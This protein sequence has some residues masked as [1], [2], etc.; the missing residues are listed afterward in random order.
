MK[1]QNERPGRRL[2]RRATYVL[3]LAAFLAALSFLLGLL[4]KTIQG[5]SPLR[6]T[7]EG[8]PVVLSGIMLGPFVGAAVG[9]AADLLSCLLAGQSPLPLITVGAAL[10]GL[11]PG[12]LTP[13]LYRGARPFS[14]RPRFLTVLLLDGAAHAVGSVTVKS[15]ALS[16]FYGFNTLVLRAPIY[17][18]IIL[19]ES[20]LLYLLLRSADVR[21]ELERLLK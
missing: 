19:L 10:V 9:V 8:M 11:L 7:L 12:L 17:L 3:C 1:H 4:A 14:L 21:R 18:G 13:L 16:A 5:T 6:V 20:Y 2:T 15:I